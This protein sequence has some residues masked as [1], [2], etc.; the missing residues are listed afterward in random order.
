MLEIHRVALKVIMILLLR[1]STLSMPP[2]D[3][4]TLVSSTS[5]LM[6]TVAYLR[7]QVFCTNCD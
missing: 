1:A 3:C 5:N 7:M 4:L 6:M 2:M